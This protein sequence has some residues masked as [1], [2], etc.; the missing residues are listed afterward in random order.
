[1]S[2]Y[3]HTPGQSSPL[4]EY[5]IL[6]ESSLVPLCNQLAPPVY[7]WQLVNR[8][9]LQFLSARSGSPSRRTGCGRR[10]SGSIF[11]LL[12][13]AVVRLYEPVCIWT[14]FLSLR[15]C[16]GLFIIH[17]VMSGGLAISCCGE[18]GVWVFQGCRL[19]FPLGESLGVGWLCCKVTGYLV[20][21]KLPNFQTFAVS[22]RKVF[23]SVGPFLL[24]CLSEH[25]HMKEKERNCQILP[26]W[27][28]SWTCPPTFTPSVCEDPRCPVSWLTLGNAH[29]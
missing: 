16:P 17:V 4:P 22:T 24:G 2:G 11:L 26:E 3:M 7:K 18:P 15:T 19:S 8:L 21:K 9:V 1:M 27:E 23:A 25:L 20:Y 5:R 10:S 29:L 6:L 12:S 14:S 28:D 13:R